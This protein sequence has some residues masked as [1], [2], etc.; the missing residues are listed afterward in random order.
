MSGPV[1]VLA[2]MT[3]QFMLGGR[4]IPAWVAENEPQGTGDIANR[5]RSRRRERDGKLV[6]FKTPATSVVLKALRKA[7]RD[8]LVQCLGTGAEV[9]PLAIH[10]AASA[11]ELLWRFKPAALANVG[12]AS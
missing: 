12:S 6:L 1:D 11:K 2:A 4:I 5:L 3:R 7:E 10:N 8:G 9:K